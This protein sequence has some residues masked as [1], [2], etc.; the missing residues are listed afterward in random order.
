MIKQKGDHCFFVCQQDA[1]NPMGALADALE[2]A[3]CNWT[4][5]RADRR[6]SVAFEPDKHAGLIVLGGGSVCANDP[7]S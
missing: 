1:D 4:L 5:F 2:S 6:N 7:E 3:G